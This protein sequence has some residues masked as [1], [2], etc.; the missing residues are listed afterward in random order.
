MKRCE[1]C[2]NKEN[3][4]NCDKYGS[5]FIPNNRVRKYFV[6]RGEWLTHI[7]CAWRWNST[8]SELEPTSFERIM[9]DKYCPYCGELMF[10]IQDKYSLEE[11]G[12]CCICEGAENELK[13]KEERK[14][15][16]EEHEKKM[17][18]LENKYKELL[19]YDSKKLFEKKQEL[20][21]KYFELSNPDYGYFQNN[22]GLSS[23]DKLF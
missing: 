14:A 17:T 8:N 20:E 1:F 21:K 11:T 7:E 22:D 23:L 13:Y 19:K 9:Y 16:L 10:V 4:A 15:L 3:C 12:C 18:E 6:N 5:R 2:I